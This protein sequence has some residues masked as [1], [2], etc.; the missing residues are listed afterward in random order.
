MRP[1][2]AQHAILS[3]QELKKCWKF[4][5]I[6]KKTS[7]VEISFK[8][9]C[10][11][12]VHLCDFIKNGFHHRGFLT[13]VLPGA[14]FQN[15]GKFLRGFTVIPFIQEVATLPKVVCLEYIAYTDLTFS[16]KDNLNIWMPMAMQML[17][18]RCRCWVFQMAF[19]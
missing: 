6:H 14:S 18:P 16:S 11:S 3:K 17:M 10:K 13:W 19:V 8:K 9:K 15:F 4:W 2:S 7:W 5:C 12:R 1:S